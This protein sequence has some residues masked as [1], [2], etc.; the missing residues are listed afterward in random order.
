MEFQG[1]FKEGTTIVD[2]SYNATNTNSWVNYSTYPV[3][4]PGNAYRIV[5]SQPGLYQ[6]VLD[7]LIVHNN[8][9]SSVVVGGPTDFCPGGFAPYCP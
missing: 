8:A 1:I 7:P 4:G 5:Q 6:F 2:N 9:Y 3:T